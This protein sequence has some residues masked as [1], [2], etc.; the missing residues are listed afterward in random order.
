[1]AE[2]VVDVNHMVKILPSLELV[3]IKRSNKF[4][5]AEGEVVFTLVFE[6][7]G[8]IRVLEMHRGFCHSSLAICLVGNSILLQYQE[9]K[10]KM[11]TSEFN[12]IAGG[13]IYKVT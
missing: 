8:K 7:D 5:T 4:L 1:M 13:V 12:R 3:L 9:K 10:N 2:L 11:T 6:E